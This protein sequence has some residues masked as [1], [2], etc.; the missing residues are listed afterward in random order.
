MLSGEER[1]RPR[2]IGMTIIDMTDGPCVSLRVATSPILACL[3]TT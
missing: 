3:E 2:E 1:E